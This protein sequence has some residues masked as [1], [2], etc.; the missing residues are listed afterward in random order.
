ML[1]LCRQTDGW[2]DRRTTVKQ[3]VPDHSMW[4]HKNKNLDPLPHMPNLGSSNS[5]ANKD[6]MAKIWTNGGT[7]FCLSRKC[8]KRR[9]CSLQAIFPFS[10]NVCKSSLFLICQNKYLKSKG[11][12]M[13]AN[14]TQKKSSA[15]GCQCLAVA[16]FYKISKFLHNDADY[17]NTLGFFENSR[18][19]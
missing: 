4:G 17:T 10:H 8:G 18:A 19:N 5:A 14:A 13:H 1:N 16:C 9:N 12:K 2:T 15:Y 3:Y 11:L 7:I 6:M